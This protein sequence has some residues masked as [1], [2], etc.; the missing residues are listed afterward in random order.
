MPLS[1]SRMIFFPE[2]I[3][4][5]FF[6][7]L[8]CT[9][10]PGVAVEETDFF[11]PGAKAVGIGHSGV[12]GIYDASALY[13][14]PAALSVK[15][16]PQG[17]L[18]IHEPYTVNYMGYSQFVPKF[19]T[20]AGSISS[21]W[22]DDPVQFA[23]IG[24]GY[25]FI[26]GLSAGINLNG[27]Q[28]SDM[29]WT[30]L[31]VGILFRPT[32]SIRQR[33]VP[34]IS[35]RL[36][37]GFALHNIPL[38]QQYSNH[39]IRL[40][41]SYEFVPYG[42]TLLYSHHFKTDQDSDH[43]GLLFNPVPYIHI[44]TGLLN[45]DTR[46][47]SFG[48]G[49]EWDNI[50]V[51][52]TFDAMTKRLV[53]STSIRIGAHP[54]SIADHYYDDALQAV[55]RRSIKSA[56]RQCEYALIYNENHTRAQNLENIL[57]P[58]L[59]KENIKIDSLLIE[60]QT[61]Q[62]QQ[63]YLSA[64]AQYLKILKIDPQN[65][66]AQ[67]AIAMIRPKINIDAERWYQKAVQAYN[68][69]EIRR[70]EELFEAILLVRPDHFGSKSYLVKIE[71][72]HS[73]IAE[74]HYFAGLGFYSQRKLDMAEAEFSEALRIDPNLEDASNYIRRIKDERKQLLSQITAKIEEAQL[75]EKNKSWN[76][77]LT[78]YQDILEI[79][80][81]HAFALQ[82]QEALLATI[83][84]NAAIYYNQGKVAYDN[85]DFRKALALFNTTLSIDPSHSRAQRYKDL[86]ARS[87]TGQSRKYID[88]AQEFLDDQNWQ[89]AI[90]MADSALSMN[91]SHI[92][93]AEIKRKAATKL[94]V[95][96]LMRH[97]RTEYAGGRFWEALE[98][99]DA[100]LAK[101]PD[102]PT[103]RS[104]RDECQRDLDALVD[105]YFNDGIQLYTEEKYQQA[106]NMW[107]QVLRINPDHKGALDYKSK[108][109]ENL[110]VLE[111]MP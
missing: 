1:C 18:S 8:A 106:I 103:A 109:Q 15:R 110:D 45:F 42:P 46:N 17:L 107:D 24:W 76:R 100:V 30:T 84:A 10:Q 27:L 3:F 78:V 25:Q 75:Y 62:N 91:P 7:I 32:H 64:A 44:Y 9:V 80:P 82:R 79:Q 67:E 19:G 99:F 12:V 95:A 23:T 33:R 66:E 34:Y 111:N 102:H 38:G 31:G 2:R 92:E 36:A 37:I 51:N 89:E 87:N 52:L 11:S 68:E 63:N 96:T 40:G 86:I 94:D 48:S 85:G 41:F 81:D 73:K 50:E 58:L 83:A 13:W 4:L 22:A 35:N 21:T 104:L 5:S 70:A 49:F 39:Q 71:S 47:Y 54:K 26:P 108:A 59:A 101:D 77:A 88:R 97:A 105:D 57:L 90:I 69:G 55:K 72:Y 98:F 43:I 20:F 61:F 6:I 74:Q 14:N 16:S 65:R 93:A 56:L 53:F 29:N 28:R 60:A